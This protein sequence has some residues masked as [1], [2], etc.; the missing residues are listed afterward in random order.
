[1][2][3]L[4]ARPERLAWLVV[5]ALASVV[6]AVGCGGGDDDNGGEALSQ[7]GEGEGELN[8]IAWAG[9]VEDGSTDPKVDWVSD[10]EKDTGC[11][12]NT[13]VAGTS[14]EMVDLMRTGEYDGVSASGNTSLRLIEGGDVDP[15][16]VDL[17]PNYKTIFDDLK[18]QP[19]NTFDGTP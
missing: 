11:Q 12:V 10:F 5:S 8:L 7:I 3:R 1:M 17:V 19:Y 4:T 13:K 15:V 18:D 14:D 6:F 16:N 2:R 9:Y